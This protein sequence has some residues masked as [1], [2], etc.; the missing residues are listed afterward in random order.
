VTR[1]VI[2]PPGVH[3]TTG[4]SHAIVK[5]GTP[6]FIAGQVALDADG[7]LVG[8]GDVAAQA[9]QVLANLK[10]VVTACGGTMDDIV[11]ITVFTTDIAHRPA[12][13]EARKK[14]FRSGHFPAS[15]FLVVSS[16]AD[17]RFLVEI[18]AVAMVES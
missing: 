6:V 9:N 13:A 11:K 4:Y 18:E 16:L 17:P 12:L 5:P 3:R 14:H 7:S 2:R 15:T 10:A 8:E 1:R